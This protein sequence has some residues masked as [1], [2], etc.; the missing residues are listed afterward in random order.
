MVFVTTWLYRKP[1]WLQ[2]AEMQE[3]AKKGVG[4]VI[5]DIVNGV[6]PEP[7]MYQPLQPIRARF[8]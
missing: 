7:L 3:A 4:G 8:L 5:Q 6:K 1:M 2:K